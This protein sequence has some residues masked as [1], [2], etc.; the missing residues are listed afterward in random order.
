MEAERR[1]ERQ[2]GRGSGDEHHPSKER[3]VTT[4]ALPGNGY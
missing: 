2:R 1:P 4:L 3:V